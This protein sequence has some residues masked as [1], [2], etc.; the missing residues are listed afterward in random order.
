MLDLG[1]E[2]VIQSGLKGSAY[3]RIA[4]WS[5]DLLKPIYF[6]RSTG[7]KQQK[8]LR[9]TAYLDGLRGFAAFVVYWHH[10][11]L[12]P[13]EFGDLILENAFGYEKRYFLACLPGVRTFFSGG[14]F[15][16]AVF[17]IISG[18]V[19][20]SKPLK[21]IYA[22]EYTKF[23]DNVASALFRRWL[24]LYIPLIVTTFLYMSSW[25][26]FGG[27]WTKSP[28]HQSTYRAEL[29]NWYKEFKN[30]SFVFRSGT[31]EWFHY[32]FHLWS[33]PVEVS[34]PLRIVFSH[35]VRVH[36]SGFRTLLDGEHLSI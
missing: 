19:L 31:H 22:E 13:R 5:V 17:F 28:E 4:R 23:G 25:H 33:I 27:I 7:T 30:F 1:Y 21:L 2:E 3:A 11:Q 15:A 8:Q 32:G 24:R 14:H 6:T 36:K 9:E 29:W 18:Y 34:K 35:S 26:A 12:W 20:S 10:H 16:V